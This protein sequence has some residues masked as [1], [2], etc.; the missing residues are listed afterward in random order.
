MAL[1][2][3]AARKAKPREKDYKLAAEKGLYLLV[4]HNGSKYWRMKFR[5]GGKEKT[6]SFGV[7]PEIGAAEATE[8]RDAA[9]K[10]IRDG[11][12][13]SLEKKK[14]KLK[15]QIDTQNSFEG[16]AREWI[17]LKSK[18]WAPLH[19]QRVTRSLELDIFPFIGNIPINQID[20][21]LLRT[22]I[23]PI[24]RRGALDIAARVRQRCGTIFQYGM[25]IGACTS[26]PA[27]PLKVVMQ[28]PTKKH[29]PALSEKEMPAFL[30]AVAEYDSHLQTR[31]AMRLLM[32][33]FVRTIELIGAR[34]EEIDFEEGIWNIPSVRMKEKRPHFVPLS[35]QALECL[36]QLQGITGNY[37]LLF[38]KRGTTKEPMSNST[39]L[40]VIDRVGYK[41][42][43][44]GHG[45]RS[46]ASTILNES[47]QFDF[48]VVERQLSHEDRDDV[49]AAYNRAK[50]MDERKRMMQWWADKVS[51]FENPAQ[52][53]LPKSQ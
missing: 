26:D 49:R 8:K 35:R 31:L 13:P 50:Y 5:F 22:V 14:D 2:D 48:D 43:M 12:D 3:L 33:T 37:P 46:V 28:P 9:R 1:T 24:Q 4:K 36:R 25:A 41:G 32:L 53:K 34:W 7:Y 15:R 47:G 51:S 45:F 6:L 42:K 11:V 21:V 39:I 10:V 30:K 18:T 17:E 20:T 16:I 40:R 27:V 29:F 23:D 19:T 52:I 44:T 38:P